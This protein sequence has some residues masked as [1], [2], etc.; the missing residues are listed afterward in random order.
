[1]GVVEDVRQVLQD[2]VTPDVR[3][4][5]ARL[6]ALERKVDDNEARARERHSEVM[7]AVKD[8]ANYVQV[9]ERLAKLEALTEKKSA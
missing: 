8:T 9:V 4:I 6:T 7:S 5:E 1:M 3:A 2:L